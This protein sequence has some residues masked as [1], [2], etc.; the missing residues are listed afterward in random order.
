MSEGALV[1]MEGFCFLISESWCKTI[2]N[3]QSEE[4]EIYVI[5]NQ[6]S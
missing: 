6:H 4:V 5:E 2:I 1:V 3:E